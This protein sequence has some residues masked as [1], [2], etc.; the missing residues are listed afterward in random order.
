L[1]RP[2]DVAIGLT[3][4]GASANVVEGLRTARAMGLVTV[5]LTGDGGGEAGPFAD[6][7]LDVPSRSTPRVQ[8][9]H[10]V[11]LH[12]VAEELESRA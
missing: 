7:L 8:E 4:S 6:F 10:L 11:L 3:T 9:A 12:L 5:A 1:G 2:G